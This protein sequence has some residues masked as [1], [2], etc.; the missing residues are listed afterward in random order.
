MLTTSHSNTAA[1]NALSGEKY[2]KTYRRPDYYLSG[3]PQFLLDLGA[4]LLPPPWQL[5]TLV[6]SV[7]T[8]IGVASGAH[9]RSRATLF[10]YDISSRM[11]SEHNFALD[12]S[13]SKE[14]QSGFTASQEIKLQLLQ[15]ALLSSAYCL[16]A[17]TSTPALAISAAYLICRA[18]IHYFT[19]PD[20]T[21]FATYYYTK[22]VSTI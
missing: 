6:A 13:I 16:M 21:E 18:A 15:I 4:L 5:A 19:C 20:T 8:R 1:S 14:Y 10:G 22:T 9:V 3:T 7:L 12:S 2:L 17:T 11:I